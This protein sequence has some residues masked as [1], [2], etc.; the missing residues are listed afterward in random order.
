M[1]TQPSTMPSPWRAS[2]QWLG[3][4]GALVVL[5][6]LVIFGAG[7]Y[8]GFLGVYNITELLRYNAMFGLLALGMTFVIMTGGIDLSVGAVAV[9]ASVVAAQLS[10]LGAFPAL[11]GAVL[12][13]AAVGLLNGAVIAW[14]GIPPFI[15]TLAALLGARGLALIL[16]NNAAVSVDTGAGFASIGLDGLLGAPYPVLILFG[17]YLAGWVL[18]EHTPFG[19]HVLAVGGNEDAT[20]LMGL[21]V[22]RIKLGVYG[23][24]G[25]LAG[26]AGVLLAA[27]TFTGLPTEGVGWELQ[28][29]AAVVVGGTLLTGGMGSVSST[30]VGTLLLGLIF[31]LLNFENGRGSI[32]LTAYWQSVIRG[33]FL[34]LVVLL[35]SRAARRAP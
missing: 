12:A 9:L 15:T 7:R 28:A 24:S 29:I 17:A 21:P 31:N 13:G 5:V 30:L 11:L 10:Y 18:Q 3:R 6:A 23:L 33:G 1:L 34:L 22:R 19:R 8:D 20:R 35:Q 2:A 26:L 14:L 4:N 16:A 27:L 32:S 25:G